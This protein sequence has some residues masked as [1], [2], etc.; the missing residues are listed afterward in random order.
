MSSVKGT[1][2]LL[3]VFI[4]FAAIGVAVKDAF[5]DD[6][7]VSTGEA[8]NILFQTGVRIPS[9]VKNAPEALEEAKDLTVPEIVDLVKRVQ[10]TPEFEEFNTQKVAAYIE[11]GVRQLQIFADFK[12]ISKG[13]MPE[14][15]LADH[16]SFALEHLQKNY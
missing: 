15:L 16:V 5:E 8:G 9:I 13:Q 3:F 14:P 7:K 2:K 12:A 6:G 10:A 11:L 1:Q 4:S